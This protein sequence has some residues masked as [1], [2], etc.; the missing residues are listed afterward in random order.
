MIGIRTR[1]KT[2]ERLNL[3]PILDAVFIFIFFLLMSAQFVDIH[4]IGSNAPAIS[5]LESIKNKRP[6]LNLALNI[7]S[8]SLIIKTG[9]SGLIHKI[10]PNINGKY[11]LKEL[12]LELRKIKEKN[13]N[14]K[15]IIMRPK[16]TIPYNKIITIMDSV[17]TI[18]SGVT[19]VVGKNDAGKTIETD[20][21]FEQI[22]FETI[23]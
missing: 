5:T 23:I 12:I 6:P 15:S 13:M 11:D 7:N 16:S 19:K 8:K 17:R 10:I 2:I 4:E 21:L 14:E 9:I 20:I 1:K 22:I 18:E 3:I